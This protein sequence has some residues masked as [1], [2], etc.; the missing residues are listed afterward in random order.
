MRATITVLLIAVA[1]PG[2]GM[3]SGLYKAGAG[4]HPVAVAPDV[5]LHDAARGIDVPLRVTYPE[6]EGPFPVVVFSH[7]AWA[8]RYYYHPLATHWASHGYAVIQP[9]HQDSVTRGARWADPRVFGPAVRVGR[10]EDL[11][12][13]ISSLASLGV[14]ALEGKLAAGRVGVGGHSYGASTALS[15]GGLTLFPPGRSEG[16]GSGDSRVKA[17]AVISGQGIGGA[18]TR[19]SYRSIRIPMLVMTGSRDP[20]R[21]GASYRWRLDPFQHA[22]PGDKVLV[23]I[24]GADH[25]F[26]GTVDPAPGETDHRQRPGLVR[27]AEQSAYVLSATTAFWDAYLKGEPE[28]RAALATGRMDALT[29]GAARVTAK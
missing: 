3:P 4:P 5:R 10:I 6:G 8:S 23:F 22:A 25:G 21:R 27:S 24:E 17:I 1:G 19:E 7:G 26:G 14:P 20:G 9:S 16:I 12:R 28:A 18:I 11:K 2:E 13:I 29:G 15:M